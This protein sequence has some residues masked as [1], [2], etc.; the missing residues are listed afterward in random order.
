MRRIALLTILAVLATGVY[1]AVKF[2]PW[3]GLL[4]GVVALFIVG[5]FVAAKILTALLTLPFKAKGAVLKGAT[6]QINSVVPVPSNDESNN[7]QYQVEVT[8]TPANANGAFS[9]WEPGEL[10]LATPGSKIDSSSEENGCDIE[11]IEVEQDGQFVA[12][13]GLKYPGPQRLKFR[14][15]VPPGTS[16]VRFRYYFEEFGE[17]R[18]GN[19]VSK[20]A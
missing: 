8:I 13:E 6:A 9:L 10:R 3:W 1:L 7:L 5:K 11:N 12:D 20:A 14:I 15:S 4:L 16:V 19:P 18:F 17:I 2:L